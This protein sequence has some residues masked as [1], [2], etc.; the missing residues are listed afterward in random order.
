MLTIPVTGKGEAN[1]Q[2]A[3][4][5]VCKHIIAAE[6]VKR[7]IGKRGIG[8]NV[9]SRTLASDIWEAPGLKAVSTCGCR[10]SGVPNAADSL[11]MS[12]A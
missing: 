10:S 12:S 4:H 8:K 11:R 2:V 9:G 7:H 5:M 1:V 6:S 3:G